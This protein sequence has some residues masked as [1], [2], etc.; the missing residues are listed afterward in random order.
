MRVAW[1]CGSLCGPGGHVGTG[2]EG[3]CGWLQLLLSV[4][5]MAVGSAMNRL[6][7]KMAYTFF[8]AAAHFGTPSDSNPPRPCPFATAEAQLAEPLRRAWQW[9][10]WEP[11]LLWQSATLIGELLHNCTIRFSGTASQPPPTN[12]SLNAL[13][14]SL[15]TCV[16]VGQC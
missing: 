12:L 14:V 9:A 15:P 7:G 16:R 4:R 10:R 2:P 1:V 13:I 5:A 6:R 8:P 11:C 3:G